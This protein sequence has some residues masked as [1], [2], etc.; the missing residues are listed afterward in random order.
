MPHD[1]DRPVAPVKPVPVDAA[2]RP[3][4][5]NRASDAASISMGIARDY[6]RRKIK[7]RLARKRQDEE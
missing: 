6:Y 2:P 1:P 5:L 4:G 7:D 3:V